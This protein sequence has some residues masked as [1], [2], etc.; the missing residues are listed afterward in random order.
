LPKAVLLPATEARSRERD[1][2]KQKADE[3]ARSKHGRACR[4]ASTSPLATQHR[5]FSGPDAFLRLKREETATNPFVFGMDSVEAATHCLKGVE[6]L[7]SGM[8]STGMIP[9]SLTL[10]S[11]SLWRIQQAHRAKG[12]GAVWYGFELPDHQGVNEHRRAGAHRERWL[13][14]RIMTTG[15]SEARAKLGFQLIHDVMLHQVVGFPLAGETP[16]ARLR[17]YAMVTDILDLHCKGETITIS[18][19]VAVTGMTRGAADEVL[20]ALGRRGLIEGSWTK[21]SMGRGQAREYRIAGRLNVDI[22]G[23]LDNLRP[24]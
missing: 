10:W 18:N 21:N 3:S 14:N 15:S 11:G 22:A 8:E 6:T 1:C 24:S 2:P 20:G 12:H 19:I 17:Q 7:T 16:G 9:T 4:A 23:L 13:R 5:P